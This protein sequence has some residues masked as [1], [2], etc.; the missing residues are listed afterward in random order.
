VLLFAYGTLQNPARRA[1]VIGRATP[2]RVVAEASIRGVLYDAGEYPVL[3]P[4][5]A[6]EDRVPGV[7]LELDDGALECLDDYEGVASGLYRRERCPVELA[8]GGAVDAWVY[9]YARSVTGLRRIAAW[10]AERG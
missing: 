4:S 9:V 1:A 8:S 6:A 10:P 2:C 7:L 5:A 3:R